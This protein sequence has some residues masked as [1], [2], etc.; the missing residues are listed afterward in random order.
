MTDD[1]INMVAMAEDADGGVSVGELE[2][3]D[4]HDE[5]IRRALIDRGF[6]EDLELT[7]N[8]R[9]DRIEYGKPDALCYVK[10]HLV[11]QSLHIFGGARVL[12]CDSCPVCTFERV[13][14]QVCD[15]VAAKTRKGH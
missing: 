4:M 2:F 9:A 7:P 15:D 12:Q 13:I 1:M 6:A 3:C 10:H 11:L 14:E 5:Q 8:E